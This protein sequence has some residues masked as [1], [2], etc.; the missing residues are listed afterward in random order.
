MRG[1]LILLIVLAALW[2]ISRL[3][4][5]GRVHYGPDDLRVAVLVGPARIQVLPAKMKE[6]HKRAKK[7]KKPKKEKKPRKPKPEEAEKPGTAGRLMKLL[8]VVT[9]AAGKLLRKIRIDELS[10]SITW[11]AADAAAAAIGYGRANALLGMIWP[12]FDHNFKVKKHSFHVDVDYGLTEPVVVVD[13]ALT[14]TLGQLLSL[15]LRYGVKALL[16]WSRSGR[17]EK[18]KQEA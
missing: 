4:L 11:A 7:P 17:P 14:M 8:P 18:R 6:K 2:L 3:R 10:L 5:G 16:T 15:G 1:W 9:E 12:L 13:A